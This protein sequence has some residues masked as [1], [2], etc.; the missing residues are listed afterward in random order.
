VSV[1]PDAQAALPPEKRQLCPLD[2]RLG[3]HQ[4]GSG[5]GDEEINS[6][7]LPRFER[8]SSSP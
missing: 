6:F 3:G 8:R 1:Q 4:R 5:N 2:R 7:P